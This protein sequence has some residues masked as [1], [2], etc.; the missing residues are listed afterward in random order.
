LK[1]DDNEVDILELITM[2]EI[3]EIMD[4]DQLQVLKDELKEMAYKQEV[5]NKLQKSKD[6]IK[7]NKNQF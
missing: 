1:H 7:L 4:G 3:S 6:Q 5:L 2:N